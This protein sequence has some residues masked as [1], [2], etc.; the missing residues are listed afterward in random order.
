MKLPHMTVDP[1]RSGF[2]TWGDDGMTGMLAGMHATQI[3]EACNAHDG[4]VEE[5]ERLRALLR[6][7][8]PLADT[9]SPEGL[10]WMLDV[11]AALHMPPNTD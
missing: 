2:I 1:E 7:A 4:L 11:R 9:E 10:Q 8:R 6:A 5:N 3:A